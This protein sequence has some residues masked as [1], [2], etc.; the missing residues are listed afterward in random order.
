MMLDNLLVT[1]ASSV[2]S[3][4]LNITIILNTIEKHIIW[5]VVTLQKCEVETK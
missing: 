3:L 2:A 5:S 4:Y 1:V